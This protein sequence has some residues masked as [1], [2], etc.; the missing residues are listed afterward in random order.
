[1]KFIYTLFISLISVCSAYRFPLKMSMHDDY[2]NSLK[3][4]SLMDKHN[5]EINT[6]LFNMWKVENVF[7]NR[8][9]RTIMFKLKEDMNNILIKSND[10]LQVLPKETK[11]YSKAFKNF[12]FY[13]MNSTDIDAIMYM[14]RI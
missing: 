5:I 12:L 10:N 14:E 11:I 1:M 4:S 6:I 2:L 8:N 13:P 3:S 9:S 7:F